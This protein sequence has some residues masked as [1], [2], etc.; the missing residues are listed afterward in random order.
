MNRYIRK[1]RRKRGVVLLIVVVMLA[2]TC[3]LLYQVAAVS[4]GRMRQVVRQEKQ[5]RERWSVLSLRAVLLPRAGRLIELEERNRNLRGDVGGDMA[6][7][8]VTLIT[9]QLTLNEVLFHITLADESAKL[10]IPKW[11]AIEPDRSETEIRRLAQ[12]SGLTLNRDLF[13][14]NV[15]RQNWCWQ[16]VIYGEGM[17]AG[18]SVLE[19][20]DAVSLWGD[21]RLNIF[22][23]DL[24][25]LESAWRIAFGHFPPAELIDE[26][27][28]YPQLSW[29]ELRERLG[30][31]ES[32]LKILDQMFTTKSSCFS[33][34]LKETDISVDAGREWL[35]VN[36]RDSAHY[37]FE[38]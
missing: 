34:R 37:G 4:F 38:F 23:S 30:V 8:P 28:H 21:G 6:Y 14:S 11:I 15:P 27:K 16:D 33:L 22:R 9:G 10:C 20:T 26:R 2:I 1:Q 12:Q 19:R 35:F 13:V 24:E 7:T 31:R 25:T 29:Q 32:Q 36:D 5:E 18:R 17:H 3:L